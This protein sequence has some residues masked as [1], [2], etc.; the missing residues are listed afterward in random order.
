MRL[1]VVLPDESADMPVSGLVE[2]GR[3]AEELGFA[4]VWLPDHLLPPG[5]Y[6]AV[7]GGVYEPLVTLAHLAAV[8]TRVTL[9]T[10]VLVLPLRDPLSLAKQTATLAHLSG[11]R[12][13]LGIGTGWQEYEFEAAGADFA[14]RGARTTAALRL[15]RHLHTQGG[16]PYEDEFHRFD[17]RAV[18]RPVPAAPVPFLIGGNSD[19][20]L[21]RAARAGDLWQG[22][23]LSPEEF[24]ERRERLRELGGE[25]VSAGARD[26][27]NDDARP[28][29][30]VVRRVR[31]WERAGPDDLALHF[32]PVDGFG[33]RMRALAARLPELLTR[34]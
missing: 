1:H 3:E 20:A 32:G 6:G 4:G 5:E 9:G 29:D 25:R 12:F 7:Y 22:F 30:D 17:E 34:G 11:G 23:G 13:V 15:V 33:R 19:A 27:W 28:L 18:F 21:R 24:T 8:T 14:R 2:L 10:S 26:D 16:G 31:D